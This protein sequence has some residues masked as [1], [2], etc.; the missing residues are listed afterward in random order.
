MKST[1]NENQTQALVEIIK[2]HLRKNKKIYGE[3]A[4]VVDHYETTNPPNFCVKVEDLNLDNPK[5]FNTFS[6]PGFTF[7][8]E[9]TKN[10]VYNSRD[11]VT[12]FSIRKKKSNWLF[13]LGILW[14]IMSLVTAFVCFVLIMAHTRNEEDPLRPLKHIAQS[15]Y[16]YTALLHM[17]Q[18]F[19]KW[20]GL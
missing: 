6:I 4:Q 11:S 18:L 16:T 13:Y 20:I 19:R 17:V 10:S 2:D 3:H 8:N 7:H 5:I 1:L 12:Y 15:S 9:S 14:F